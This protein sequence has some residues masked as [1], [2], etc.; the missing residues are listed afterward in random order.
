M[1]PAP[2]VTQRM[3]LISPGSRSFSAA[4]LVG[5]SNTSSCALFARRMG[6]TACGDAS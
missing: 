6:F 1:P 2:A 4:S 3:E 5:F